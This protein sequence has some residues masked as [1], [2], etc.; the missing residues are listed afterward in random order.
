[1]DSAIDMDSPPESGTSRLVTKDT[2]TITSGTATEPFHLVT[3]LA[4][5]RDLITSSDVYR[6]GKTFTNEENP[7]SGPSTEVDPWGAW[8]SFLEAVKLVDRGPPSPFSRPEHNVSVKE[9]DRSL[10]RSPNRSRDRSREN[11]RPL[12]GHDRS[13]DRSRDRSPD[14]SRDHYRPYVYSEKQ[15]TH[16]TN[17]S[18]T[19]IN[20][21]K[22]QDRY[23]IRRPMERLE[24][25]DW[26]PGRVPRSTDR[27]SCAFLGPSDPFRE[28]V[29]ETARGLRRSSLARDER[30]YQPPSNFLSGHTADNHQLRI[31]GR[32]DR[33]AGQ[34][35]RAAL[36]PSDPFR[37]GVAEPAPGAGRSAAAR[38]KPF[39]GTSEPLDTFLARFENFSSYYEWEEK[40]R[41]FH[42]QNGLVGSVGNVLWDSGSPRRSA[43]LIGLLRSRFG[44]DNQAER[45]RMELKTRRR[46]KGETLQAVY[47]DI[48]R[49]LALALPGESGT[50]VETLGIDAFVEAF[51]DRELRRQVLQKGCRTLDE[52]L[53]WAIRLEAIE[54][55]GG[56][57]AGP[58]F[59]SDGS[60]HE[61]AFSYTIGTAQE[62]ELLDRS[63]KAWQECQQELELW[64]EWG[65]QQNSGAYLA[66]GQDQ[67]QAGPRPGTRKPAQSFKGVQGS[68]EKPVERKVVICYQCGQAG[69]FR[70]FCPDLVQSQPRRFHGVTSENRGQGNARISGMVWK[71][72][73]PDTYMPIVI[74]GHRICCLLDTGCDYSIIPRR[75]VP[76]AALSPVSMEVFAANGTKINVLGCMRVAFSVQGLPVTADLL[77]SDDVHEFM[78]G[79]DWLVAQQATWAFGQRKLILQGREIA[80]QKRE[81]AASVS[82]VYVSDSTVVHPNSEGNVPVK[83]V[84]PTVRTTSAEW[85]VEPRTLGQGVHLARVLLPDSSEWAAV[86][87]INL[88]EKEFVLP[89]GME[90]GRARMARP[91]KEEA[92]WAPSGLGVAAGIGGRATIPSGQGGCPSVNNPTDVEHL[93]PIFDSLPA[94]MPPVDKQDAI[95]FISR[96][97]D[98]FSKGDYDLGRTPCITHRIDTGD[99]KPI[100]QGLR[101]HPQV[102]MDVIDREVEKLE[103]CGVIEPACSPWASNVVVV[104]KHDRTPRITLDYRG[105]NSVTYKDSYPLPNIADCLDAFKGAS[106]FALL[107]LRSSFYQVPL[108]IEDRDKT[109]FITRRGQWRF[110]SLPMGLTNSPG[111]FQRLMDFVLR[112][113]TWASVL[114]YI[115]DIV[116]YARSAQELKDRLQEVFLRLRTANLKLKPEKVKLFQREIAFLG[117]RV[118]GGGVSMDNT[119]VAAVLAWP[120]PRS[121]HEVKMFLGLSGYYRR[122]VK[123]YA[124]YAAPLQQLTKAK[125]KFRW[126]DEQRRAFNHLKDC[127]VAA[128]VLAMSKD[129]GQYVLDVDASD[130]A[131]G[132]VL[133]QIQEGTPKVIGYA[134]RSFNDCEKRYCVTRKE[135]AALVFGLK[136]YRQ[137]LLGR[138][139]IVRTDHSALLHLRTA[140][141]LIG[142]QARWLDLIEEF[143]FDLQHRAGST[144]R[145]ADAMSRVPCESHG[146][147]CGHCQKHL[148]RQ[149]GMETQVWR[150]RSLDRSLNRSQDRSAEVP[151]VSVVRTRARARAE[152]S[153]DEGE[154]RQEDEDW[155]TASSDDRGE[156]LR[157]GEGPPR[158]ADS[159]RARRRRK[160]Q[161]QVGVASAVWTDEM[162]ATR[163]EEDEDLCQVRAWLM[164]GARPPWREMRAGSP[165]AKAYWHQFDSLVMRGGVVKRRLEGSEGNYTAREQLL[166]PRSLR[167]EFLVGVHEGVAGHLGAFKTRA[168]VGMRAYW[169]QWRR[170]TDLHCAGCIKCNQY[171]RSRVPPKQGKLHPM[172]MGAPV[173]RWSVDLAGPFVKSSQGF[174][175]ILTAICAFTKFIVLVPLRDK[176]AIAVARAIWE[177]VFL[178]YGAG[179]VL[180]DNGLEFRNE[181]MDELC[182]M[183]GVARCFTT[184]YQP[185]TNGQCERNHATVNSIL[186]KCVSQNQ[187]DWSEH[188]SQVAFCYNASVHESTGFTPFFLLHGMEPRWDVDFRL[189]ERREEYSSNEYA[190]L[191]VTRLENAHEL[192]RE[193]LQ[194]TAMRM[195][196]WYD[197]KVHTQSFSPGDEVFV[198]NLRMYQGRSSKW[199]R[200]YT[201]VATVK[202]ALN[203]V[204][205]IVTCKAWRQGEKVVHVDKL[206]LKARGVQ[207]ASAS[208]GNNERTGRGQAE[209]STLGHSN[210]SELRSATGPSDRSL[211]RSLHRSPNRS[212]NSGQAAWQRAESCRVR[213]RS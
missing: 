8:K 151:H 11:N 71:S 60:K 80:L 65:A 58:L 160:R 31:A 192:A 52:A 199:M 212:L 50:A 9:Q 129:E 45:F 85:M 210:V 139:F 27:D 82:R 72:A 40:E 77:V 86:R 156:G 144:H 166:M 2:L 131:A 70:R 79:Y 91:L 94:D 200:R 186:A 208:D 198:L 180:T 130:G 53:T 168:H 6:H 163:Q 134:S 173:E 164:A 181:L 123:D 109:A 95:E 88:T 194:T 179:E 170:D 101:R 184:S 165:A 56:P 42:L 73:V 18:T 1:M 162:L 75:L 48:K 115:D 152:A 185:R 15:Q 16:L 103:A 114:V 177:E 193:Q 96:H 38:L 89:E 116:V 142:Q 159:R 55:S 122:F 61:K 136:Q 57:T 117:H 36:G 37:E 102:Y 148:L 112:G 107:D 59:H 147:P 149:Q 127:L 155:E 120:E 108:A 189:G 20:R 105:L 33:S 187:R 133:Q 51:A 169:Y 76:T 132:A 178:K 62:F 78:L 29:A 74:A 13:L 119:K 128:P 211:D 172:V 121:A 4:P 69:H 21:D 84:R 19:G 190:N 98:V 54:C 154:Q 26:S 140:P 93:R 64:R 46:K 104:T 183:F 206:K 28:G 63:E 209:R 24:S 158:L 5:P 23:R 205:Y 66:S 47:H 35:S 90:M 126:A 81:A 111:T 92:P 150:D 213:G 188:L 100:R 3:P 67:P 10:D 68:S 207:P 141:E 49:L 110:R 39:D 43:D 22:P 143:H 203:D 176:T 161:E 125:E 97:K 174:V 14:R 34:H 182:R 171:S 197:K 196:A 87:V 195:K 135:L 204:T 106:Y 191:L 41:L 99:A 202:K 44:T 201:D 137:Y 175:Y 138:Q 32:D 7:R 25:D 30:D 124:K 118:S 157:R 146:V 153:P 145:N 83:L 167:R 113:L 12:R 17:P